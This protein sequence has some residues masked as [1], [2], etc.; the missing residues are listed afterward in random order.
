MIVLFRYTE[1]GE[2]KSVSY[3]T[4]YIPSVGAYLLQ[5]PD[6]LGGKETWLRV[7]REI[8]EMGSG[9]R[10]FLC[11]VAAAEVVAE[12]KKQLDWE[13]VDGES[14]QSSEA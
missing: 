3:S 11:S 13:V 14:N 6:V 5:A 7:D 10:W 2:H 8:V 1:A 12:I 9:A 4:E